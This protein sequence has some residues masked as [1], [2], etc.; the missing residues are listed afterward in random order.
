M[1]VCEFVD[2]PSLYLFFTAQFP[3]SKCIIFMRQPSQFS[4]FQTIIFFPKNIFRDSINKFLL[5]KHP[6]FMGTHWITRSKRC[7]TISSNQNGIGFIFSWSCSTW[8]VGADTSIYSLGRH[9]AVQPIESMV[10]AC[11]LLIDEHG[12]YMPELFILLAVAKA[13]TQSSHSMFYCHSF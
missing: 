8:F 12:A 2:R 9:I 10:G 4:Y 13:R 6:W 3:K 11:R 5:T 1:L 7:M